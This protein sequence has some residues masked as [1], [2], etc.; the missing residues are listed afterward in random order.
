[1]STL[2]EWNTLQEAADYLTGTLSEKWTPRRVL[3]AGEKD[4]FNVRFV[5]PHDVKAWA[6]QYEEWVGDKPRLMGATINEL[7]NSGAALV[8]F[9]R[10]IKPDTKVETLLE[11][12]PRPQITFDEIRIRGS[13]LEAFAASERDTAPARAVLLADCEAAPAPAPVVTA[14][15][16]DGP[17]WSLNPSPDRLPGYRWPLYCFLLVAHD[18]C[19]SRPKPIEVLSA[20]REKLP[21]EIARVSAASIDYYD[22]DGNEQTADLEAIRKAIGRMTGR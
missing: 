22:A 19:K 6:G 1:M 8:G 5:L 9:V 13:E 21:P 12:K 16:S 20:W 4:S 17:G 3:D 2:L 11:L 15:A 18:A 14:G 7:L 10:F